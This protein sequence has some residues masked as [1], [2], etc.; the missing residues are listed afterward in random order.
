M[1]KKNQESVT[2][3]EKVKKKRKSPEVFD[4]TE[5]GGYVVQENSAMLE[6]IKKEELENEKQIAQGMAELYKQFGDLDNEPPIPSSFMDEKDFQLSE[7]EEQNLAQ[8][9]LRQSEGGAQD[10]GKRYK[11]GDPQLS[12]EIKGSNST[13]QELVKTKPQKKPKAGQIEQ[14]AEK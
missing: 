14:P 11:P 13:P 4:A 3:A 6:F 8:A 1:P 9:K 10:A 12:T 5:K 2:K 7:E